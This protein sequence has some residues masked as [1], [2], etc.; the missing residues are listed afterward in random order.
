MSR[1]Y[2]NFL[3]A[4]FCLLLMLCLAPAAWAAQGSTVEELQAAIQN[5]DTD[6][7]LNGDM[8]IT[9][10]FFD[11]RYGLTLIVPEN[12]TLE[13]TAGTVELSGLNLSGGQLNLHGGIFRV[14]QS[15][16]Y[17]GGSVHVYGCWNLFPAADVL[18]YNNYETI[19]SHE[20]ADGDNT[21]LLFNV[22]T[23]EDFVDAVTAVNN[24]NTNCYVGQ[25]DVQSPLTI[26]GEHII[27]HGT[28]INFNAGL[29][30]QNSSAIVYDHVGGTVF[31][32]NFGGETASEIPSEIHGELN[33]NSINAGPGCVLKVGSNANIN[34]G[35]MILAGNVEL[36]DNCRFRIN[37]KL[38]YNGG[39]I[40]NY[41]CFNVYLPAN[42]TRIAGVQLS[43]V[44]SFPEETGACNL[45]FNVSNDAGVAAVLDYA[46][47]EMTE[48][49][50]AMMNVCY[51]WT[52]TGTVSVPERTQIIINGNRGGSLSIGESCTLEL[53]QRGDLVLD[54]NAI[55]TI[56]GMLVGS[57]IVA[58][59]G[60]TL[61]VNGVADF[62][63]LT[64][65]GGTVK[66]YNN[67]IFRVNEN[68]NYSGGTVQVL[69][70][71]FNL[72]PA[73]DVL[74]LQDY[75]QVF[76]YDDDSF[77]TS[78]L[79]APESDDEAVQALNAINDLDE[80]FIADLVINFPWT[81]TGVKEIQHRTELRV[82][83]GNGGS[84]TVAQNAMF[85]HR[86][87]GNVFFCNNGSS[88]NISESQNQGAMFV[89]AL[90]IEPNC[91]FR[92]TGFMEADS[93]ELGGTL[94]LESDCLF[95]N[96]NDFTPAGGTV[97]V[98][99]KCFNLF[100]AKDILPDNTNLFSYSGDGL[101]TNLLFT[102]KNA[103]EFASAVSTINGLENTFIAD[104]NVN[105]GVVLEG[106]TVILHKTELRV[107][108]DQGGFLNISQGAL[109]ANNGNGGNVFITNNSGAEAPAASVVFGE[110]NTNGL[111]L[112]PGCE[113]DVGEGGWVK[114]HDQL[115]IPEGAKLTLTKG[116]LH[117]MDN[118]AATVTGT[119][120]NN[121]FINMHQ[122]SG[123]NPRLVIDGGV[124]SGGGRLGV[125]DIV[126]PDSYFSGLDLTSYV[127]MTDG[128]GTQYILVD[129]DLILPNNLTAIESEAFAG[130][131]FQSIYIPPNVTAIADN[132]F[133]GMNGLT[134][135][136]FPRTAAQSFA[137]AQGYT[138]VNVG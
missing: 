25:I 11:G 5:G 69:G 24:L 32:N 56:N 8:S 23:E 86:S 80:R 83:G 62:N 63:K 42:I 58:R 117:L 59:T 130:G 4:L 128:V 101:K 97:Q 122:R 106:E 119:L 52:P 76:S 99:G 3:G 124:Y 110:L 7:T 66:L 57:G 85:S 26:T 93:L 39:L 125:K 40:K 115:N 61:N 111:S 121:G 12:T 79:F 18:S 60:A 94:A 15:F 16:T 133:A 109:L 84:L 131:T 98:N 87:R 135:Y 28:E 96:S 46:E 75:T 88:E 51:N 120:E 100:P 43:D 45:L 55:A 89:S 136:G 48:Q 47:T 14:N 71:C 127:K 95:R 10:G 138:F 91:S 34:A 104:L 9:D 81:V 114:T 116:Q 38:D 126:D 37:N 107:N 105:G 29:T 118:S 108:A 68:L 2:R 64:L 82:N 102:A 67:C 36:R 41:G 92:N 13:I 78:L 73:A 74:A 123:S 134:I 44:I 6:F 1:I 103:A 27:T 137:E 112:A 17:T 20:R 33:L 65:N 129:A 54:P 132:A 113:L 49:F 72:F 50:G 30:M 19:F 35:Q 21:K 53:P 22:T 31:F 70:E 77:V 90:H